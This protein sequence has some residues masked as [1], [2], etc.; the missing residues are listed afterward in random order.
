M[1]DDGKLQPS[2]R[3]KNDPKDT[4]ETVS[5]DSKCHELKAK[6]ETSRAVSPTI[7]D[8]SSVRSSTGEPASK[9]ANGS[10]SNTRSRKH[11][12]TIPA[13][14]E[15]AQEN[16]LNKR[17]L[18]INAKQIRKEKKSQADTPV[19]AVS[20]RSKTSPRKRKVEDTTIKQEEE[21]K[22]AK[23]GLEKPRRKRKTKE[24]KEAEAMPLAARSAGLRMFVGAHVSAA[25]GR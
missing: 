12:E 2:R 16:R 3:T 21:P 20:H 19:R 11:L 23:E 18:E 7:Y 14:V 5:S 24:E 6:L 17:Y 8:N 22:E 10:K 1:A 13:G 4:E 25:K 9:G 15:T